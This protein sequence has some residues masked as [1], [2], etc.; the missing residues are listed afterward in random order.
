MYV[1]GG[2]DEGVILVATSADSNL[3]YGLTM[4]ELV[5][6]SAVKAGI[7]FFNQHLAAGPCIPG[8]TQVHARQAESRR[9]V[10]RHWPPPSLA[11]PK[12]R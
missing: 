8:R 11:V 2:D 7:A 3:P 1:F 4:F 5:F 12:V 9:Q 6:T 10:A